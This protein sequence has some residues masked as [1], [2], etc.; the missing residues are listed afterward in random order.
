MP[1]FF[2]AGAAVSQLAKRDRAEIERSAKEAAKITL[3][4]AKRS[5]VQP[6]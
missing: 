6:L 5:L 4:P 1:P 3:E 2:Q